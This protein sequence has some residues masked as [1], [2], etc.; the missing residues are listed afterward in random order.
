MCQQDDAEGD[1]VRPITFDPVTRDADPLS[2]SALCCSSGGISW[3]GDR[4]LQ[5]SAPS[6]RYEESRLAPITPSRWPK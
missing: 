4:L 2:T 5:K 3:N 1:E 6:L